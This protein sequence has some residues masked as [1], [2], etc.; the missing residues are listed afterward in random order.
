MRTM[1]K[2]SLYFLCICMWFFFAESL[3]VSVAETIPEKDA[4]AL[5]RII[6]QKYKHGIFTV[7]AYKR[8]YSGNPSSKDETLKKG[9]WRRNVGTAIPIDD[10]GHLITINSV[11]EDAEKVRL[12]RFAGD[13]IEAR[14]LGSDYTG[15][16]AV[17]KIDDHLTSKLPKIVSLNH[18]HPGHEIFFLGVTPGMS[19]DAG[20]G[21]I[22]TIQPS[23]G[24][25]CI[26]TT[27]NPGTS[28]T[29][30]FDKNE[31][32]LGLLAFQIDTSG[33]SASS[34][35][36]EKTY[37]VLSL[38]YASALAHSVINNIE[39]ECG[40]LG[41]CIDPTSSKKDGVLIKRVIEGSPADKSGIIPYDKI[42]EFNGV[43]IS[44]LN[45]LSE[46]FATTK[47]G[48]KVIIKILRNSKL[49]PLN[50]TLAEHPKKY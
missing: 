12:I 48:D 3:S 16:I 31:N 42:V 1:K 45:Q 47:A 39:A 35:P 44:S 11:V 13:K 24:T 19:V 30:V 23:D 5:A 22:K 4:Q 21:L 43:S 41:L 29:P 49:L 10:Q 36:G 8:I 6:H 38:E 2:I 50:I 17:L 32:L 26:K 9:S 15:R 33:D 37:I 18:I 20:F 25:F 14:V 28:G 34:V 46:T 27:V 7:N 40:W